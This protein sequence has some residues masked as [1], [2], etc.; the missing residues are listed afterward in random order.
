MNT[1]TAVPVIVNEEGQRQR[2]LESREKRAQNLWQQ[3]RDLLESNYTSTRLS[4]ADW[5]KK[6]LRLG[7]P[8]PILILSTSF[9]DEEK[10]DIEI[11]I[12]PHDLFSPK[13]DHESDLDKAV[14]RIR[15]GSHLYWLL[16][17]GEDYGSRNYSLP[18]NKTLDQLEEL[19]TAIEQEFAPEGSAEDL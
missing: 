9:T 4:D 14:M 3:T 16:P 15:V 18:E 7:K 11:E 2:E 19:V 1:E 8:K 12:S 5:I 10:R 13:I 17:P 6:K